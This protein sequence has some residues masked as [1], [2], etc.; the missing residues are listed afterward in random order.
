M[1]LCPDFGGI[2]GEED[3]DAMDLR[4]FVLQVRLEEY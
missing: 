1:V 2:T 4:L 3:L